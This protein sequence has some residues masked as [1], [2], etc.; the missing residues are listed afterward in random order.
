MTVLHLYGGQFNSSIVFVP[1]G[2]RIGSLDIPRVF[3]AFQNGTLIISPAEDALDQFDRFIVSYQR[4]DLNVPLNVEYQEVV[5]S[6]V[7][8]QIAKDLPIPGVDYMVTIWFARDYQYSPNPTL[9][10]PTILTYGQ[11]KLLSHLNNSF[12]NTLV[13]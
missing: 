12:S 1:Y 7:N 4:Q 9:F 13:W 2:I 3:G 8:T 11:G 6:G 10:S 5:D